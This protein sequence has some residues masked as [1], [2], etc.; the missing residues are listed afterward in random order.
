MR[1]AEL[2]WGG[3][4]EPAAFQAIRHRKQH[5]GARN[6]FCAPFVNFLKLCAISQPKVFREC[7][8]PGN[9]HNC[10]AL[11]VLDSHPLAAFIPPRLEHKTS[12]TGLHPLAKPMCLGAAA[13]VW[14]VCP[15][16]HF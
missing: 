7:I 16:W 15:L 4:T 11:I 3:E 1:L 6:P 12:A 9:A 13:I 8:A 2:S 10:V 5:K 14:L